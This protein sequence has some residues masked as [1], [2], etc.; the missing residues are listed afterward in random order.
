MTVYIPAGGGG[1]AVAP[2]TLTNPST[3]TVPLT[4]TTPANTTADELDI[5]DPGGKLLSLS[6][7]TAIGNSYLT[8]GNPNANIDCGG[9]GSVL[10]LGANRAGQ[11]QLG[12]VANAIVYGHNAGGTAHSFAGSQV[13]F[14]QSGAGSFGSGAGTMIFLGNDTTDPTTTPSGGG[15]LFVS[16]G[17]LKYKGSSGTVTTLGPA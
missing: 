7:S 1:G 11:V 8:L 4:I 16:S 6:G 15:I 9:V 2:L 17:A 10:A 12:P 5:T 3:T 13:T 14:S